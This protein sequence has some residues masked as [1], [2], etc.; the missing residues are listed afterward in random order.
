MNQQEN[1]LRSFLS[2]QG[3]VRLILKTIPLY[4]PFKESN[5]NIQHKLAENFYLH[6]HG[7]YYKNSNFKYYNA[8][9]RLSNPSVSTMLLRSFYNL[10]LSQ[11]FQ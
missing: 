5:L 2:I 4:F 6:R 8:K 7:L 9:P 10:Q 1:L 3:L 11:S